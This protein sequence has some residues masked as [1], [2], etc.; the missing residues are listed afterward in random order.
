MEVI[1]AGEL[2]TASQAADDIAFEPHTI[3]GLDGRGFRL[4]KTN[5]DWDAAIVA[6]NKRAVT[7]T[8]TGDKVGL[9]THGFLDGQNLMFTDIE[10]TTG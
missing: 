1:F 7:F 8:D 3:V 10:T 6:R 9:A 4:A 5:I 2:T